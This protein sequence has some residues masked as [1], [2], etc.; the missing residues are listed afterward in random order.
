MEV[1]QSAFK[2]IFVAATLLHF[3]SLVS[4]QTANRQYDSAIQ[5]MIERNIQVPDCDTCSF[6]GITVI[7]VANDDSITVRSLFSSEETYNYDGDSK[8]GKHLQR[9]LNERLGSYIREPYK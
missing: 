7:E 5:K 9:R 2:K 4:G 1:I 3:V 8:K 6:T